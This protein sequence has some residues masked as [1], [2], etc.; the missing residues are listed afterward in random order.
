MLGSSFSFDGAAISVEWCIVGDIRLPSFSFFFVFLLL[1]GRTGSCPLPSVEEGRSFTEE[2]EPPLCIV[3]SG[4]HSSMYSTSGAVEYDRDDD[5]D[6]KE[7]EE[8]EK[9]EVH[10][11]R[12]RRGLFLVGWDVW[13]AC[14]RGQYGGRKS[15]GGGG[16]TAEEEEDEEDEDEGGVQ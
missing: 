14:V 1:V 4:L 11:R 3:S 15:P 12:R 9:V 6:K 8:A 5:D 13:E 7:E 2:E 16:N 10:R